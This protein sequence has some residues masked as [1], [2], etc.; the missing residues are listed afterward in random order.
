LA[1]PGILPFHMSTALT[2]TSLSQSGLAFRER[3]I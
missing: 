2:L 3:S 1:N